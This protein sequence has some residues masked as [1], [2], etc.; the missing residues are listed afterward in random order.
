MNDK[1]KMPYGKY[2]G[3]QMEDVPA[4]YLLWLYENNKCSGDV[5]SYI[6]ENLKVIKMQISNEK[7]GI[8]S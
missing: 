3:E 4:E 5:K 6:K 8:K 1:S 2:Q 7:K